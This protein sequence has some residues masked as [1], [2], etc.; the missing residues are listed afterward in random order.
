[1]D[2]N[3]WCRRDSRNSLLFETGAPILFLLNQVVF[4]IYN[5]PTAAMIRKDT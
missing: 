1:M 2:R 3:Q 4:H 5:R